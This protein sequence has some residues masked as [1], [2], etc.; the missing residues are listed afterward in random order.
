MADVATTPYRFSAGH[1]SDRDTL[2]VAAQLAVLASAEV[3]DALL[4]RW[5]RAED[6]WG[7]LDIPSPRSHLV[8]APGSETVVI[9]TGADGTTLAATARGVQPETIGSAA[10]ESVVDLRVVAGFVHALGSSRQI[11]RRDNQGRWSHETLHDAADVTPCALDGDE[12]GLLHVAGTRGAV[13][14]GDGQGF[15]RARCPTNVD[16]T[17]VS[18]AGAELVFVGG[19]HG[20]LLRGFRERWTVVEHAAFESET[21]ALA[22]FGGSLYVGSD[23]GLFRL[24]PDDTLEAVDLGLARAPAC[25]TLHAAA[26]L[27]LALGPE[28]VALSEDGTSWQDLTP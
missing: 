1:V 26:G 17:S 6:A 20:T 18:V 24:E 16:L 2:Y 14:Y 25:S 22:V 21:R 7:A 10:S 13:W 3:P 9:A 15:R 5:S 28:F 4:M 19:A 27:L 23:D 8:A 12:R 11:H